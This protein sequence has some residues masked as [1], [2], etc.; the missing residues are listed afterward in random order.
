YLTLYE[1]HMKG[2][3]KLRK[4]LPWSWRYPEP[5]RLGISS[6]LGFLRAP[7][8]CIRKKDFGLKS[9]ARYHGNAKLGIFDVISPRWTSL[10]PSEEVN[11]WFTKHG[12][13]V[14]RLGPGHYVGNKQSPRI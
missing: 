13:S 11:G 14:R 10:H 8:D 3:L 6:A 12:F 1:T 4:L 2:T 7:L 9:L 5:V